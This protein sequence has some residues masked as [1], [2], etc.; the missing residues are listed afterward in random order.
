MAGIGFELKKVFRNLTIT[1]VFKGFSHGTFISVGPMFTSILIILF[2]EKILNFSNIAM[3]DREALKAAVMY[4]YVFSM[5]NASGLIMIISRY[6][7]DKIY[8]KDT[9][10]ILASLIGI[11]SI[12]LL[13]SG[14]MGWGF[15]Y[16]SPLPL[17]FKHLSFILFAELSILY[18]LMA[19]ISAVKDYKK[20]TFAFITGLIMS[21]ISTLLLRYVNVDVIYSFFL[22]IIIGFFSIILLLTLIIK[23]Y[24]TVLSPNIFCFLPYIK[25]HPMLFLTNLFYTIGIFIHNIIFWKYS[26]ISKNVM[27]T[28]YFAPAYDTASFF[29]IL[30][31]IPAAILFIV[32]METSFYEK[33][34]NFC[35]SIVDGGSLRDLTSTKDKMVATLKRELTF[36]MEVQFIIT[37]L[38]IVLGVNIILPMFANDKMTMELYVFL[39]IGFFMSYMS[40][41]IITILIYFDNQKHTLI[42]SSALLIT[43]VIFTLLSIYLGE[44]YF[45]L[46]FDIGALV[47]LLV[48]LRFLN[49]SMGEIDYQIFSRQKFNNKLKE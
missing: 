12:S 18:I 33:Y 4:A 40:F 20:V 39:S 47:S 14:I 26:S 22:G 19:Y 8:I 16:K 43:T 11:V 37:V 31:T 25:K 49:R 41:I 46:G 13:I 44:D 48:S 23:R 10:D 24:F 35:V 21:V 42:V 1:N 2:I 27:N 45:G 5:I 15:Y 3:S 38:F 6:I 30:T 28:F 29:A 17:L 36:I 32:K 9:T 7:A 34:R